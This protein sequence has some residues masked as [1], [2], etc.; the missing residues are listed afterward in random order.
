[1]A[2]DQS[3]VLSVFCLFGVFFVI[4]YDHFSYSYAHGIHVLYYGGVF[5]VDMFFSLWSPPLENQNTLAIIQDKTKKC[6]DF[7]ISFYQLLLYL[8]TLLSPDVKPLWIKQNYLTDLTDSFSTVHNHVHKLLTV[9]INPVSNFR[10]RR[11]KRIP[12]ENKQAFP[13]DRFQKSYF[14]YSFHRLFIL[15]IDMM[16]INY[17]QLLKLWKTLLVNVTIHGASFQ[18]VAF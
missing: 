1:M 6:Q 12:R 18:E 2:S 16:F 4:F 13:V 14:N 5:S 9:F 17:R 15:L 8:S 3:I 10:S 11:Y 7:L